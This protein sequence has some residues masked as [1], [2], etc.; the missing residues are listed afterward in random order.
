MARLIDAG[1]GCPTPTP[2]RGKSAAEARG[3]VY[4]DA[5]KA[6]TD[7]L[8]PLV[9]DFVTPMEWPAIAP[10]VAGIV[11]AIE[12][13]A[14]WNEFTIESFPVEAPEKGS[15][16]RSSII[17]LACTIFVWSSESDL[18]NNRGPTR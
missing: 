15:L 1:P 3:L 7:A 9:A 18:E 8:Y 12:R 6:E 13:A 4:D 17:S 11:D 5:V 14:C 2:L 10:L 16:Y